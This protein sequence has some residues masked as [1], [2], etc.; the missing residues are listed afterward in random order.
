M[1]QEKYQQFCSVQKMVKIDCKDEPF[2]K[3]YKY[4]GEN[5]MWCLEDEV[6]PQF[7]ASIWCDQF[8]EVK[9]NT[10]FVIFGT[11]SCEYVTG[12]CNRYPENIVIF[13]E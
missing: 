11:G 2:S 13:F 4:I 5:Q 6:N 9:H 3:E 10:V 1:T 12:L 8:K 7:A